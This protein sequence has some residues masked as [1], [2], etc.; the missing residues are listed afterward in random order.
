MALNL[1]E[2]RPIIERSFEQKTPV[3]MRGGPGIGKSSVCKQIAD[4]LGVIFL[5]QK[6]SQL[7][8][9][10]LAGIAVPRREKEENQL[11]W[12]RPSWLPSK[13]EDPDSE[14]ILLLDEINWANKMQQNAAW[15][16]VLERRLGEHK[17]PDGWHVMAAGNR[18]SDGVNPMPEPLKNRF[19]HIDITYDHSVWHEWATD[20]I[21]DEILAFLA[22]KPELLYK[23]EVDSNA[24]PTPRTWEYASNMFDPSITEE[25]AS[26]DE[27]M[28]QRRYLESAVGKSTT[29]E[30]F[31][32]YS[33]FRKVK[34]EEILDGKDISDEDASF[35]YAAIFAVIN[36]LKQTTKTQEVMDKT[37]DFIKQLD[38]EFQTLFIKTV[39][40]NYDIW[41]KLEDREEFNEEV[42]DI[43]D[44]I[45]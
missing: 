21:Q 26:D 18:E 25:N 22:F 41:S 7:E 10:E 15:E 17:I 39:S 8:P 14:G 35:K 28:R 11:D 34:P 36:H 33:V 16:L 30:F 19:L 32:W 45:M 29:N 6:L 23:D 3:M 9:T 12:Y 2:A 44:L 31:Q 37:V 1:K 40:D 20:K 43:I 42:N 5:N 4:D 13:D 38:S 24:F 27:L